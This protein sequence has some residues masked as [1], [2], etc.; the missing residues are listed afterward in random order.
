MPRF[1]AP[2]TGAPEVTLAEEQHEYAP[3]TVAL[4]QD[5]TLDTPL[6]LAR[7]TF[8]DEERLAIA[9]GEDL[10]VAEM[11]FGHRFTPLQISVGPKWFTITPEVT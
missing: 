8:S 2:R 9:Q 10:Y 11:T 5:T 3:I 1:I 7:I 6:M 4:Y